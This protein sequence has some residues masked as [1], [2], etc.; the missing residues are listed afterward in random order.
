M[1]S[2]K[3]LG[4]DVRVWTHARLPYASQLIG[5]LGLEDIV[6]AC[7][8]KPRWEE[9]TSIT[10]ED[11]VRI[12]GALPALTVDDWDGESVEGVPFLKVDAWDGEQFGPLAF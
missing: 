8:E 9:G 4:F 1:L 5:A 2:L 12:L 6:T 10:Q 11:A 7:H 3:L